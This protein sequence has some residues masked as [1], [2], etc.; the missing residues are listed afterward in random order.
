[1]PAGDDVHLFRALAS[2]HRADQSSGDDAVAAAREAVHRREA[3]MARELGDARLAHAVRLVG[4]GL[5]ANVIAGIEP[6]PTDAQ[7]DDLI[8]ALGIPAGSASR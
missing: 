1:M 8:A 3:L 4:D 2:A 7:I 6:A 5:A